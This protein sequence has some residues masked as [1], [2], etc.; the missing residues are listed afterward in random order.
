MYIEIVKYGRNL[1]INTLDWLILKLF[2]YRISIQLVGWKF[3]LNWLFSDI[4]RCCKT[5]RN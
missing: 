1:L 4:V 5:S 3:A 2:K